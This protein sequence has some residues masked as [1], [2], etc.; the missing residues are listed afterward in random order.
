M[1]NFFKKPIFAYLTFW[2]WNFIFFILL[3]YVEGIEGVLFP[4]IKNA[5]VGYTPISFSIYSLI[6]IAIPLISI[7]LGLTTLRQ[8]P[9]QLIQYF[10]GFEIPISLLFILRLWVFRELTGATWHLFILLF[11]GIISFLSDV[12]IPVE[13]RPNWLLLA[14]KVGHS[15]LLIIGLYFS[16]V[17]LFYSIPLFWELLHG[18]FSFNWL[19]DFSFINLLF[20]IFGFLT[21]TIIAILPIALV[22]FYLRAFL[23][24][25]KISMPYGK[26]IIAGTLA[27]N[28]LLLFVL[29]Y[30]QPQTYAFK[31]LDRDFSTP[32]NR[33]WFNEHSSQIKKGLLNAYLC[34]YRYLSSKDRNNEVATMYQFSLGLN[35]KSAGQVQNLYNFFMSPFL[36]RGSF[37]SDPKKAQ[38]LYEKYFD[39]SIQKEEGKVIKKAMRSTW[40]EDGIEAGLLNIDQEKVFLVKQEITSTEKDN[41]AEIE[42]HEVYQN[43]TFSQQ[44]IFYYFE[45]PPNS[46]M[47]GLWLSDDKEIPKKYGFNVSPRGA[48]Q[49]I[50]KQEVQRRIDPSL[51]EQVGP[52][53]YR[54]RAFP[55]LPK[56]K[57]YGKNYQNNDFK[58]IEGEKFYLW[59]KYETAK[60]TDNTYRLPKLSEKR[61]IYWSA[62]TISTINGVQQTKSDRWTPASIPAQNNTPLT[63]HLVPISEGLAIQL[64]RTALKTTN[65]KNKKIALLIDG[66]FSMSKEKKHLFEA[67]GNFSSAKTYLINNTVVEQSLDQ[68][69]SSINSNPALFF[70]STN[71]MEII[72]QFVDYTQ[73]HFDAIVFLT[74]KGNYH[75]A[76]DSIKSI[77]LDQPLYIWHISETAAPIYSDAFLETL[78][79]SHGAIINSIKDLSIQFARKS[80]ENILDYQ[81]GIQYKIQSAKPNQPKS[82]WSHLAA[83]IFIDNQ[84]ITTDSN[85]ISQL[86]AIHQIALKEGI[87]TPY[88]S[89]I[90]LVNDRQKEA[91]KKAEMETDRFNREVETGHEQIST[92]NS[93]MEV[94][95]TPE[96]E[97]WILI[98][99]GMAFVFWSYRKRMA[100]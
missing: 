15:L 75:A 36:Y 35:K 31:E 77:Q 14:Q 74:D 18:L 57:D 29:N 5:F 71:N 44:E 54:L 34:Q 49:K 45:L 16:V 83:K 23:Q 11:L 8:K 68:L 66:S 99:I 12:L 17:M 69:Q 1:I 97:E 13:K 4:I 88:S 62:Q 63:S 20:L 39:A 95:G 24:M 84:Q 93:F 86:D 19:M 46:V 78:N 70:G 65:P 81:D 41:L 53:Q 28:I 25:T 72:Q 9:R 26:A 38:D 50:Y 58:V 30:S 60:T 43:K 64:E 51:L 2:T 85:R 73:E 32:E 59:L 87:V 33:A 79:N 96:P 80:N 52:N 10:Y 6:V 91:L 55:I 27:L 47:T 89:M 37:Y 22:W 7:V 3:I 48:A 82:E 67:L 98:F 40:D 90:V 61:N 76:N 94:S 21:F 100:A 42:I 56:R 92:I